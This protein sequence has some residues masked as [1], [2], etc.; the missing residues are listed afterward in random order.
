M[1][2]SWDR[3]ID[4]RRHVIPDTGREDMQRDDIHVNKN[5]LEKAARMRIHPFTFRSCFVLI[6]MLCVT[7][8]FSQ[9]IS[10]P[11]DVEETMTIRQEK[12]TISRWI[13][14][15]MRSSNVKEGN[16]LADYINYLNKITPDRPL[17]SMYLKF[18]FDDDRTATGHE[19]SCSDLP[20]RG[21]IQI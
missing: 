6:L 21:I 9:Q 1:S 3:R 18:D 2:L 13:E 19:R 14:E 15:A 16:R 12:S 10:C 20:S 11:E 4:T 8:L 17:N 5:S 7:I